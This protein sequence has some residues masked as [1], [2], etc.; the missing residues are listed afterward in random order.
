MI[1]DKAEFYIMKDKGQEKIIM[2]HTLEIRLKKRLFGFMDYRGRMIDHMSDRLKTNQIRMRSDGTRFDLADDELKNL[3]FY[4]YE[5][6]GFQVE[7]SDDFEDFRRF[8]NK[9]IADIK[10]FPD[11]IWTEGLA[12]IGTRTSILYHRRYDSIQTVTKAYQELILTNHGKI[13]ELT[14]S[15][16][17]DTAHNFEM[18]INNNT[19]SVQTGPVTREEGISKFFDNKLKLYNNKFNKDNALYFS[20]DVSGNNPDEVD[21]FEMLQKKIESQI[22]DIETI[23]TGFK[24]YFN[25]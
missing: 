13:S 6:F 22:S 16:I 2:R 14:K 20:I 8:V 23:F 18:K 10:T 15:E 5:N 24:A 3:Y 19:V 1:L 11:Y 7:A 9:F 17:F 21:D 4:S 12:R 25:Q